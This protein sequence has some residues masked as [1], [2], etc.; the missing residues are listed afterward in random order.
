MKAVSKY[1]IEFVAKDTYTQCVLKT[2]DVGELIFAVIATSVKDFHPDMYL[3]WKK[4][5]EELIAAEFK[6][7]TGVD[8]PVMRTSELN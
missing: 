5:C 1:S 6:R 2:P 3:W 7:Q 4:F 8:V